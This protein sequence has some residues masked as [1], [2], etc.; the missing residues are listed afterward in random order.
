LRSDLRAK[1]T[2]FVLLCAGIA[3]AAA[4]GSGIDETKLVTLTGNTHPL[5]RAE[6][7]KGAVAPSMPMDRIVL[8]L[9]RTPEQEAALQKFMAEQ[10]DPASPNFHH[11]LSPEEFGA[12]YGP[13]EQNIKKLTDWLTSHGFAVSNISRGKGQ[14]EFSGTAGQV[15]STFHT[16]IHHYLVH[17]EM[18]IA[19][20]RDPQIPAALAPLI[21]GILSLH[22]FRAKPLLHSG[23]L[24]KRPAGA[25]EWT[26]LDRGLSLQ[27]ALTN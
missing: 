4:N 21:A 18:H 9:R 26:P 7:D 19:N 11:W 23:G 5:A 10:Q 15:L 2:V 1:T 25:A 3:S 12:A 24:A 22:D 6:F 27:T 17:G 20:S 14:I 8:E 13:S 16:E